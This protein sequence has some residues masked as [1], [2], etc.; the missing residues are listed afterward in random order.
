MDILT[1]WI[2][3]IHEHSVSFHLFVSSSVAFLSI[4]QF[5]EYMFKFILRYFIIF[6]AIVNKTVFLISLSDSSFI[7]E[8]FVDCKEIQPVHP[9]GEKS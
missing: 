3:L 6:D 5:S 9:K 2:I 7:G 4:L 8:I 1:I